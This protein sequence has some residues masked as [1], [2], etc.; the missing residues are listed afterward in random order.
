MIW[1]VWRQHRGEGV[2]TLGVL[3][4]LA[5]FL[6][7]TGL[8]MAYSFQHPEAAANCAASI[9]ADGSSCISESA[10]FEDHYRWLLV[11]AGFL[12]LLPLLPG[13]LVGAPLVARELEQ[14]THVLIL[15][16]SITRL[17]WLS[18]KLALVLG[19]GL[20]LFSLLLAEI[21]WWWGPFAHYQGSFT[22]TFFD[23]SGPVFPAAALLALALGV[24]AGAL[25]RRTVLAIFLTIALFLAI[26][27]PVDLAWRPHFLPPI[28]VTWPIEQPASLPL[29]VNTQAWILDE[30]GITTQGKQ[31]PM[32][33]VYCSDPETLAECYADQG[34]RANYLTYQPADRFW[35]FQWIETG[36]YAGFSLLALFAASWLVRRRLS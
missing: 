30:G 24:F 27:L 28:I 29:P 4:A 11:F 7:I 32:P 16:Q 36:I 10:V 22:G 2:I 17:R 3:A 26:W 15:T 25:T 35:T 34:I 31:V 1:V 9:Q 14:R 23:F 6:L 33:A 21:I 20:L 18:V 12:P 8:E 5:V 19:A 13:M